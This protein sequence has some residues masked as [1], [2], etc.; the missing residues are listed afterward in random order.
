MITLNKI[1]AKAGIHFRNTGFRGKPGMTIKE[2]D[3]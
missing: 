3:F 1:S 2:R